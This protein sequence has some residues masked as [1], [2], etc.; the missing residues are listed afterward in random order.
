MKSIEVFLLTLECLI[1]VY[2][3]RCSEVKLVNNGYDNVVI[4]IN[5]ELPEDP[6][7]ITKI[8]EMVNS[9]SSFLFSA[10]KHR[11]YYRD[12][13]I[14]LPITWSSK[15]NYQ[16][17]TTQS[18]EKADVIIANPHLN[19]GDDPY[20]LQ[21]GRC[22]E[23]G[24]YIHFT[25]NFMLNDSLIPVYGPRGKVF[26]HEWAH[27]RWGVFDEYNELVPFYVSGNEIKTTRCSNEI[28]GMTA[29]CTGDSCSPCSIDSSTGFPNSDC[30]F[31]P[32]KNQL[33][34][35]SIMYLQGLSEVVEFCDNK[36]H[37][38]EAPNM[39]NKMCNY[40]STWDVISK[41]EDFRNNPP[42]NI[43]PPRP[44]ITLLHAKDRVLCLVLDTSGSMDM[45]G[46]IKRLTQAAGIFLLQ[47]IEDQ[48]KVGIVSFS[49]SA[50]A[51]S[52]LRTIDDG[53]IRKQLTDL[54]P[55]FAN[56]GTNIC[57]G[58]QAGLEVLRGDDNATDGDEI[59]LLTDGEDSGISSCFTAVERSGSVI[60]TIALGPDADTDLEK[61]SNMT[62]GL[63]YSATD[64]LD[65]NGLIDAFTG[66][67]SGNGNMSQQS[68]QLESSGKEIKNNNWFNG[69]VFIDKT[70]GNNTF[71]VITWQTDMPLAF[72]HDPSGNTYHIQAFDIDTTTLTARLNITGTAQS[73]AWTYA[74]QNEAAAAQVITI[75]VT[76]R[77]ADEKVPPVTVNA[78]I[79]Q[80]TSDWPNP[81]VIFAE[82]SH[83][84]LPVVGAEVKATVERP[85]GRSVDLDLLDDGSG[86]DAVRNDGVYSRYFTKFGGVGRYSIKVSV[87]GKDGVARLTTRKQSRAMY[88]PG[89]VQNGL[90]QPNPAKPP[91][92]GDDSQTQLGSFNRVKSGG[93]CFVS[94]VPPGSPQDAYPP[95]KI[96]DLKATIAENKIQLRWT[97]PGDDFDQGNA[98]YYEI[99]L[100]KS[101]SQLKDDF[102]NAQ[103]VNTDHLTPKAASSEEMFT[104]SEDI[105]LK[106]GTVIYFAIRA[107]DKVNLS[108]ELSNIAQAALLLP[109]VIP[110]NP[111]TQPNST[112]NITGIL[113]IVGVVVIVVCLIISITRQAVKINSADIWYHLYCPDCLTVQVH[114]GLNGVIM[115]GFIDISAKLSFAK[116][117]VAV[118]VGWPLQMY[119]L[120]SQAADNFPVKL[121]VWTEYDSKSNKEGRC[122]DDSNNNLHLYSIFNLG[123]CPKALH[124]R[125][126]G[127]S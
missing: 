123:K 18:Y 52:Q 75:T 42:T 87:Q 99:R 62:G 32:D 79:S 14:L 19:Y 73:G 105:E 47:I 6:N 90:I 53:N 55:T 28:K 100:S 34:P 98:S 20:T 104:V 2:V 3:A 57:A 7:L 5:P 63:Q 26:V 125:H 107:F 126:K 117:P 101:F 48:S 91:I 127:D 121:Q 85:D 106:N 94:N 51:V 113:L 92:G 40:R 61:L 74:I 88:I 80:D 25:S 109:P 13:K 77:A 118:N 67:V 1:S 82:V 124:K 83:G 78:H 119:L 69:T 30:M 81:L 96:M 68:I 4:A 38:P 65:E 54:L 31:F 37:N 17:P 35:A 59:V 21:Y 45:E 71:F 111:P 33:S 102:P 103:S 27:L 122:Q 16:R 110:S 44:N 70:I 49:Y 95:S 64:K 15:P 29:S 76:S 114:A 56:G 93:I 39:Q 43:S 112:I 10:T 12:V 22:G 72:V 24:R 66:L 84:F 60:H 23:K 120:Y 89:Y 97:A 58:V 108:S 36:T 9:A 115:V 11:A 86:S 46:R 8:E 116:F 41:S 50:K